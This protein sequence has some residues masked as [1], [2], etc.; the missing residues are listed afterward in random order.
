MRKILIS[1]LI[2]IS[3]QNMTETERLKK[4]SDSLDRAI[5]ISEMVDSMTKNGE[6]NAFLE[7]ALKAA[8][9][10]V[11][12]LNAKIVKREY[13]DYRNI[14]VSYKNISGKIISA[15]RFSWYGETAFGEP[16]EMG[17]VA[18]DGIGGGFTETELSPN[19]DNTSEWDI[20]SRNAKKVVKVWITEVAY[21]DGTKWE[22]PK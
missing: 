2:L 10:P 18:A 21:K 9:A 1:L 8:N 22:I 17:N 20:L 6:K 7:D 4:T 19:E 16:A 12:I 15:I 14:R 5:K 13:S 3:C 11:K